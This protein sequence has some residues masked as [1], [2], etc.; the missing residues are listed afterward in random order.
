MFIQY[1]TEDSLAK[2]FLYVAY[3]VWNSIMESCYNILKN[4]PMSFGTT[5]KS[6]LSEL[7]SGNVEKVI[8]AVAT[9]LLILVF[10]V[11]ILREGG[12]II[13]E[14]GAPYAVLSLFLRFFI[15]EALI[16]CY[17]YIA[18]TIFSIFT[19]AIKGI[20]L[21][22]S[23]G[24]GIALPEVSF[25]EEVLNK[26]QI[27]KDW[28]ASVF[29]PSASALHF[30]DM[31]NSAIISILGL[32]YMFIVIA[33]AFV[34]FFKVYGRYFKILIAIV[35]APIGFA[36]YGSPMTEQQAKKFLFYLI[37]LAAE[38]LIIFLILILYNKFLG[39]ANQIVPDFF[40]KMTSVIKHFDKTFAV[41]LS[42]MITQIFFCILL[43]SLISASEKIADELL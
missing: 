16:S 18:K 22:T 31:M 14:K 3:G 10:V 17:L 12:H 21:D 29:N 34:V 8:A 2:G 24:Y 26:F 39:V 13:S 36:L 30:T 41:Y 4:N 28:L 11:G 38:G 6:L 42:Y 35:L 43:V 5:D 20:G 1:A 23:N 32:I 9:G 15:C 27:A 19:L 7:L 37:K 40:T 33:C 25:S